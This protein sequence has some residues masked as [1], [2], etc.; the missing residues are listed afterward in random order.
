[1]DSTATIVISLLAI[2]LSALTAWRLGRE[3]K[4]PDPMHQA[5]GDYPEIPSFHSRG[6]KR[7]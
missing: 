1:M 4:R 6:D 2:G 3:R 7:G 5:F